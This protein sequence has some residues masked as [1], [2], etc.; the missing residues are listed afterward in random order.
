M[1]EAE[2]KCPACQTP[3]A[4]GAQAACSS[5]PLHSDCNLICCPNCGVSTVD[6]QDSRL[7]RW[8]A[9]FFRQRRDR[10]QKDPNLRL[11]DLAAGA[12]AQ[13]LGFKDIA[14]SRCQQLVGYGL[15]PGATV[16]I[17]QRSPVFLV[18]IGHTELALDRHLAR[19]VL[20]GPSR[21]E[22]G[23]GQQDVLS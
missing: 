2:L 3:L 9:N 23:R 5:C 14:D 8:A 13:V 12:S 1:A 19:A 15:E 7:A 21:P 22:V 16:L 4:P 20:V 11:S 18:A 10:G 17:L 6:P